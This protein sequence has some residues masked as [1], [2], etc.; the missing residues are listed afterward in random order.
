MKVCLVLEDSAVA[1]A[2]GVVA[3]QLRVAGH[4]VDVVSGDASSPLIGAAGAPDLVLFGS[5]T[6]ERERGVILRLDY[7]HA[8]IR[9][10][11][12]S[13]R[14]RQ[15]R[16]RSC[17]REPWTVEWL[18]TQVQP[19]DVVYDIGA[20]VGTFS[21]IAAVARG[22]SVI[23]F[24]PGYANFARLCENIHLNACDRQI[25]PVPFPLVDASG[26]LG[27]RYRTPE[28][29]ESRH[30][31]SAW[32]FGR[33]YRVDERYRQ[34]MCALTLDTACSVFG[35]PLPNHIKLDVDGAE[36][37]V[38]AGARE[39][40][41]QGSLRTLVVEA[42]ADTWDRVVALLDEAGF[43]LRH[44]TDRGQQAD[45]PDY[46]IFGRKGAGGRA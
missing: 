44:R 16:V 41:A 14:E 43:E 8:D 11:V 9:M 46:G 28:P 4:E 13:E 38:L 21:L 36:L 26:L 35:F 25:V 3:S 6:I 24:E 10:V 2:A 42:G 15:R 22:A 34:P 33:E 23:A 32:E 7:P 20:N 18:D 40:L 31:L 29:G 5:R 27:F 37:R 1:D 30:K 45:R 19:G 12:S 17:Q 39:T